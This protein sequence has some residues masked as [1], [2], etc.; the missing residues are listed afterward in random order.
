M[1]LTM[2]QS[3]RMSDL[4]WLLSA[5]FLLERRDTPTWCAHARVEN[6]LRMRTRKRGW[7]QD[8]NEGWAHKEST[9][10]EGCACVNYELSAVS[11]AR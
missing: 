6:S 5:A 4:L 9:Q 2:T 11:A 7:D 3:L 10:Q 1:S 8:Q